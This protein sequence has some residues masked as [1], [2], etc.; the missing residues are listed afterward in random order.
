MNGQKSEKPNFRVVKAER[1]NKYSAQRRY[2][3][4]VMCPG[5]KEEDAVAVFAALDAS[6]T[7]IGYIFA[8]IAAPP[9]PDPPGWYIDLLF[10]DHAYRRQG[11]ATALFEALKNHAK[12]CG[13]PY[14]VAWAMAT[15]R[16]TMFWYGK[17]FCMEK[18]SIKQNDPTHPL[19]YG[20]YKHVIHRRISAIAECVSATKLPKG[21]QIVNVDS[22]LRE[23]LLDTYFHGND[24]FA[25]V[26]E[27]LFGFTA[28]D[29]HGQ[30]VGYV[31]AKE[32][33]MG[34]PLDET[35][36]L[37][38]LYVEPRHRKQGIGTCLLK[39]IENCAQNAKTRKPAQLDP[40]HPKGLTKEDEAFYLK[41]GYNVAYYGQLTNKESGET[42]PWARIGMRL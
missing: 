16:A 14:F 11:I 41:R 33:E 7:V 4:E 13:V 40:R 34:A 8:K 2:I 37:V 15:V 23:R 28:L 18:S 5:R 38:W 19:E 27:E 21:I 39:K 32:N 1:D 24:Y 20:N 3:F 35:E 36:W 6:D 12:E 31:I 26:R 30:T 29:A 9:Q 25:S 10:V 42:F 22:V 17:Q